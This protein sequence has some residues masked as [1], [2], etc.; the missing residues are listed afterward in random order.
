MEMNLLN[1][2]WS[3]AISTAVVPV[4]MI[5]ACSLMSLAFYNRLAAIVTRLRAFQRECLKSQNELHKLRLQNVDDTFATK[6]TMALIAMHRSQT[7]GVLL[8]ARLLQSTLT[9]LLL[10]IG[11]LIL[12]SLAMGFSPLNPATIVPAAV[13]F[14]LGGLFVFLGVVFAVIEMR[15]ALVPIR[16]ESEFV[17]R[18]MQEFETLQ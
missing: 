7:E 3:K 4:V 10:A 6:R 9:C 16:M 1:A 2:D 5:S 15:S 14:F 13:L 12:S 17:E 11:S 8:R 18:Q